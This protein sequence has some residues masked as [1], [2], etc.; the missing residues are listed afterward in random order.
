MNKIIFSLKK[1]TL[2]FHI[3]EDQIKQDLNKANKDLQDNIL[4]I[5]KYC[6]TQIDDK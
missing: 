5:R 6:E 4:K 2:N 1:P 3:L